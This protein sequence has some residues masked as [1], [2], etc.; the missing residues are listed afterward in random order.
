MPRPLE[1]ARVP[2]PMMIPVVRLSIRLRPA[3]AAL[4]VAGTR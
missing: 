4:R 3:A 2:I 1:R